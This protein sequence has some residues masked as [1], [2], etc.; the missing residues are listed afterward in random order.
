MEEEW[1]D[2]VGYEGLYQVSNMGRIK[3]FPRKGTRTKEDRILKPLQNNNS[4]QYVDLY[5]N[6]KVKRYLI[7]RLVA[8]TFIDNFKNYNCVNHKDENPKNN[9]VDNLEWC[10]QEYNINYGTGNKR[11]SQTEKMTILQY[12]LQLNF[13]KQWEGLVEAASKLNIS[14]GNVCSCCRGKRKHAGGYIWR[15]KEERK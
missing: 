10:T 3:S 8:S 14:V 6:K 7:H 5:K 1:R 4:Y 13:I 15:Y 11:R 9:K 12:D 2:V